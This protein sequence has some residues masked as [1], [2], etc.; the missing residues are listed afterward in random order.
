MRAWL[1]ALVAGPNGAVDEAAVSWV[2]IQAVFLAG[3]VFNTI[4]ARHF[5]MM[6]F[7]G[8]EAAAIPLYNAFKPKT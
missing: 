7:I 4:L 5:P 6:D 3:T 8:A 2:A 1:A